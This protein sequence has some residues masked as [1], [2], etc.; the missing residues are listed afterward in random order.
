MITNRSEY[1]EQLFIKSIEV[2]AEKLFRIL[3]PA[4]L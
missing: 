2:E 3:P 4:V 1:R